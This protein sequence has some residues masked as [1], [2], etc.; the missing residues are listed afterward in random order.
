ME[1]LVDSATEAYDSKRWIEGE[2]AS[3]MI[4]NPAPF[5]WHGPLDDR[6]IYRD[7]FFILTYRNRLGEIG[8]ESGAEEDRWLMYAPEPEL[9]EDKICGII[10][11]KRRNRK[12]NDSDNIYLSMILIREG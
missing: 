10:K 7:C 1:E 12:P 3:A 8:Q 9:R 11:N 6:L 5:M 2:E 4:L